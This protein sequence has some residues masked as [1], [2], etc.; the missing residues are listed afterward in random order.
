MNIA[1]ILAQ[2]LDALKPEVI[3]SMANLR[4]ASRVH[5]INLRGNLVTRP[6]PGSTGQVHHRVCIVARKNLRVGNCQFFM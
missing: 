6:Q 5:D 4:F 1:R 2:L 3:V